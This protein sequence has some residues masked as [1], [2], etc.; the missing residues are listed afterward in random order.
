MLSED[1]SNLPQ[2]ALALSFPLK[3]L[4][5]ELKA[6]HMAARQMKE[7][8]QTSANQFMQL[9]DGS[10]RGSAPPQAA[11]AAVEPGS[12]SA[13]GEP[14][15]KRSRPDPLELEDQQHAP[16]ATAGGAHAPAAESPAPAAQGGLR[17]RVAA[18]LPKLNLPRPRPDKARSVPPTSPSSTR[19]AGTASAAPG[20]AT[21]AASDS[22]AD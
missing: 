15:K 4:S 14:A 22:D 18:T 3:D 20:G 16:G 10:G 2:I 13:T 21:L 1:F 9:A 12:R 11:S 8:M 5:T 19:T 17:T 6:M 7:Q